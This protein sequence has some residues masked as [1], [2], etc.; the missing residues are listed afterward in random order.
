MSDSRHRWL[1]LPAIAAAG[2]LLVWSTGRRPA[3]GNAPLVVYCTHDA[4]YAESV[5]RQF[6]QET[7]I[8]VEVRFDTEATKT[9][10]L[11]SLLL[12]EREQP[13]CDVFWNNELLG[14]LHLQSAGVLEPYEGLG[15]KRIPPEYRDPAGHWTGFAARL[16]VWIVNT[17]LLPDATEESLEAIW[18]TAPQSIAVA[19]PL[20]GT[21][22]TQY[23]LLWKLWGPEKLQAW[24]REVRQHGV[25]EVNGNGLVKDMVAAGTC[26]A[27][28]TDTDDTFSALAVGAPVRMLPIRIDGRTVVI[29]NTVAILRG[30]SRRKA[31]ERLV[32]YLLSAQTELA[33]A[34]STARQI[35]LGPV[36][37]AELPAEVRELLPWAAE[38]HDLRDLLPAR[39]ACLEWLKA[40]YVQ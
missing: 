10:G 7:G 36:P 6:E 30:T 32:D 20:Y 11:V 15:W 1:W 18:S 22:L 29:P 23:S 26:S 37:E 3:N 39:D 31:A 38:G 33:L 19:K 13:R 28:W 4:V 14:M 40:E 25:R 34:R 35:P 27:G 17:K 12:Q 9:L 8:P 16:R 21:T 2:V 5:L 24:H